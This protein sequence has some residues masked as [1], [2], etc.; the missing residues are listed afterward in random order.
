MQDDDRQCPAPAAL[1]SLRQH[2][3]LSMSMTS[4]CQGKEDGAMISVLS[5]VLI[6][7]YTSVGLP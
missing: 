2:L 1:H 6:R 4:S 3:T 5:Q 7:W